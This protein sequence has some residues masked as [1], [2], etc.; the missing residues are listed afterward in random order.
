MGYEAK[1][2]NKVKVEMVEKGYFEYPLKT[3]LGINEPLYVVPFK[4]YTKGTFHFILAIDGTIH[5]S[6]VRSEEELILYMNDIK[7]TNQ[8]IIVW[9]A[10]PNLY[11]SVDF[12]T[13]IF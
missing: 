1:F 2:T 8:K 6:G 3:L 4:D 13:D 9:D 11:R 10:K 12:Y 7:N 5:G